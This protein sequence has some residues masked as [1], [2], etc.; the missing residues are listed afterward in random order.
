MTPFLE[1]IKEVLNSKYMGL[2]D[3]FVKD[4][5]RQYGSGA[6][7]RQH[8]EDLLRSERYH[9]LIDTMLNWSDTGRD[10]FWSDVYDAA[11]SGFEEEWWVDME[12]SHPE[13]FAEMDNYHL[14]T[15]E[16]AEA[17]LL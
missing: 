16:D 10:N 12:E 6:H 5:L 2:G 14:P 9:S 4:H 11:S 1:Q 8:W 13:S 17:L 3:I 15:L 7:P